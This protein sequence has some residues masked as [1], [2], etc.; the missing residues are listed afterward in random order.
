M[1]LLLHIAILIS[2]LEQPAMLRLKR[3]VTDKNSDVQQKSS[4][5]TSRR[6]ATDSLLPNLGTVT[7][8]EER[9]CH[10]PS[11]PQLA[12]NLSSSSEIRG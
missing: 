12:H 3:S 1:S 8:T 10:I 7:M 9:L 4:Y 5:D 2:A 6:L 11:F